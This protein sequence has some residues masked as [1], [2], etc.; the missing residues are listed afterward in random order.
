MI[1]THSIP[2]L[3]HR[4]ISRVSQTPF[5]DEECRSWLTLSSITSPQTRHRRTS[6]TTD[7]PHPSTAN[8]HSI[9]HATSTTIIKPQLKIA[10]L[11]HHHLPRSPVST[12]RTPRSSM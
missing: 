12:L 1:H 11:L 7:S 6:N 9:H 8:Q 10:G 3:A 5:I 4:A 2:T